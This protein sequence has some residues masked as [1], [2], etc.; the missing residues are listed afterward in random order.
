[1]STQK[2]FLQLESSLSLRLRKSWAPVAADLY[3]RMTEHVAAGRFD[4]ARALAL[5]I[6]LAPVAAA[7]REYM[8]YTLWGF[9]ILGASQAAEGTP[10]IKGMTFEETL[11]HTTNMLQQSVALNSTDLA[12]DR[13]LQL[14]AKSEE[15]YGKTQKADKPRFL[16][17]FVSF[18]DAGDKAMQMVSS[19]HSTRLAAWGFLAEADV[20]GLTKYR[21]SAV[22]DGRTSDFC[23]QIHN[24][25]FY[26]EDGSRDIREILAAS[27]PEDLKTLQPWPKQDEASLKAY[28]KMTAKQLTEKRLHIPPFHPYCRTLL[29]KL[30]KDPKVPKQP[31]M[32]GESTKT[33]TNAQA[34]KELGVDASAAQVEAWNSSL[35]VSPALLLAK[36]S[37]VDPKA[38]LEGYLKT[39]APITFNKDGTI[40]LKGKTT[41]E[42]NV[43]ASSNAVF[44]PYTQDFYLN[45]AEFQAADPKKAAVF[46]NRLHA[47]MLE[48]ATLAGAETYTVQA[49]GALGV[50]SYTKLGFA[51]SQADWIALREDLLVELSEGGK[52][53]AKAQ[54]M[55]AAQLQMLNDLLSVSDPAALSALV[56]LPW[57]FNGALI[58]KALLEGKTLNLSVI[59]GGGN[60]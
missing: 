54:A 47:Q 34:F 1:M 9:A 36:I 56:N 38:M 29:I 17:E 21:L 60:A 40:G 12:K 58:G 52:F 4:D 16:K 8:K 55:P 25:I 11:N 13:A 50:Y 14:I 41:F 24:K 20:L 32:V 33:L 22:I 43:V 30:K 45:Y 31:K 5:E 59:P 57:R 39:K 48:A 26:V 23:R 2:V 37:G 6:D 18:A 46:F 49:A 27:D 7:N 28:K 10:S 42:K 15:E 51:P 3:A 19:L 35:G 44:D 53:Y